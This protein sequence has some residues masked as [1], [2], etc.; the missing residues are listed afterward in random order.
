MTVVVV[1][2]RQPDIKRDTPFG[3]LM[4]SKME[5]QGEDYIHLMILV[6]MLPMR[7]C[8]LSHN[9]AKNGSKGVAAGGAHQKSSPAT[10]KNVMPSS[11]PCLVSLR[12]RG[13]F[14]LNNNNA[15]SHI[16]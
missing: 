14:H 16:T 8:Q 2:V 11:S 9:Q 10:Q 7:E 6:F 1:G 3:A 12:L 13:V 5:H 15:N 4:C